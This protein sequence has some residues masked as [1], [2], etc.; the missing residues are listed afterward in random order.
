[1]N[2]DLE[3]P[4]HPDPTKRRQDSP[5]YRPEPEL[6]QDG[7]AVIESG[8]EGRRLKHLAE[9]AGVDSAQLARLEEQER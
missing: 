8:Q 3:H 5:Q 9:L 7:A 1:M 6:P 4:A 2:P